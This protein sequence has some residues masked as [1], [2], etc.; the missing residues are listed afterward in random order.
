MVKLI[1]KKPIR[2]TEK[3]RLVKLLLL[4]KMVNSLLSNGKRRSIV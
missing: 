3:I 2:K 1:E 4:G